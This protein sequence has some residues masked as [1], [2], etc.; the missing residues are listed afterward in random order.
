MTQ[1][2]IIN[3]EAVEANLTMNVCIAAL[4]A[5]MRALSAGE[6]I[7]PL[8]SFAPIGEDRGALA[9]MPAAAQNPAVFGVK[10][11]SL[12]PE[13][14]AA[15]RPAIQGY[16]ALFDQATGAPIA[17]IDGVSVTAI[18]TAAASGLATRELARKDSRTQAV[19]GTGVQSFTHAKAVLE[20]RPGLEETLIWGRNVDKAQAVAAQLSE[21]LDCAVG[22]ASFEEACGADIIS[23]V[24]STTDPIIDLSDVKA[25]SH[26]NLV[27]SHS[28]AKR[29][30]S[31]QLIA[32]SKLF[33]DLTSAAL[34]EAGDILTPIEEGAIEQDHIL[35]EIGELLNG[36]KSFERSE[37]DITIYKSLGN[38]AQDLFAASALLDIAR[39]TGLGQTVEF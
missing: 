28:P 34:S 37:E 5:A 33:V 35:A 10:T 27:G 30:A 8:R 16:V 25:G 36:T 32:G 7:A 18:R 6:I 20:A 23:A 15:G 4:D 17:L 29:E 9:M 31:S 14:P 12:L 13:N 24:T 3:R 21:E 39:D 38:A 11:L 22:S 19:L 2:T 1:L 26:I